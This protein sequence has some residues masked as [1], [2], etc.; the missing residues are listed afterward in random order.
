M[1]FALGE[2][3]GPYRI[4]AQLGSGGMATVYKA[5]HA[6]LDR[7]VAIKVLHPAFKEDPNFLAR[8]QREAKIVAKL[9]HPHIVPVYDFSE[10]GGQPYL[11]MRFI[12][13]ETLKARLQTA[14]LA[15]LQV[16]EIV[17]PVCQALVYAHG[18]G[19]L[20]RDIKPSNILLTPGGGVF[21]TDFGLARM[22]LAGESTLTRDTLVGTPQYIS[23]E[24]AQGLA[25]L[26][27]RTD[28]YS[29][30][31]VLYE[32]LV[33]R[34][35]YQADTPYAVVHDH[36]YTPLPMPRSL[37]A[38]LP[39]AL[40]RVLL[41]ALA[42]ERDD[43]FATVADLL[44]ALEK[45]MAE[46]AE[47]AT[48][49]PEVVGVPVSAVVEPTLHTPKSPP[50]PPIVATAVV[51][52]TLHMPESPP[53][54]PIAATAIAPSKVEVPPQSRR[55]LWIA[56][57]VVGL[58][59]C[60]CAAV[61]VG[62]AIRN[63]KLL[64]KARQARD[65]GN[66]EQAW[67]EYE[68]A[69]QVNS[70]LLE[71]YTEPAE[72]LFERRQPEDLVRAAEL[73]Q[74]GLEKVDPNN[75]AL[76]MCGARAWFAVGALEKAAPHLEWLIEKAPNEALPHA[77]MALVAVEQGDLDRAQAEAGRA[78]KINPEAIEVQFAAGV[79]AARMKQPE[80]ARQHLD[81]VI[82]SPDAPPWMRERA[83][84]ALEQLEAPP[85]P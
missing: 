33:G 52:P 63:D 40:E 64:Q 67:M 17:R 49:S 78:V 4:T 37:N 32:L 21:L 22:A 35:P 53:K 44:A 51:E 82:N 26:D 12:E 28:I 62:T 23:P 57:G 1:S 8:F 66:L 65:E 80:L 81:R 70:K 38:A 36:I 42:K 39:E 13:G 41:K 84:I 31:V 71:A 68:A 14:K 3:V 61:V 27:A 11:V 76:H 10:H 2:N 74:L 47:Q 56:L 7:Y 15:L 85:R 83:R 72:M 16:M 59:L 55:K 46:S 34:V 54:L 6:A 50:E 19:V 24:Q 18:Q 69:R 60:C 79:V 73:C 9:E 75:R 5:Y 43:R 77:G 25:N 48:P 29:L 20:H 30:G 58:L 45:A